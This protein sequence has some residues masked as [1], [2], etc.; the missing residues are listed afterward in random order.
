MTD[1]ITLEHLLK[2]MANTDSLTGLYNRRKFE[3]K[4]SFFSGLDT[5]NISMIIFDINGLKIIND[6]WDIF[7]EIMPS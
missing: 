2:E 1:R 5:E 3:E 6:T 7:P 4:M